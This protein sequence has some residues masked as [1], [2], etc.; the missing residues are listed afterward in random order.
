M[1]FLLKFLLV[2]LLVLLNGY[3]VASEFALVAVRKTRINELVK[4]G[5]KAAKLV[6]SAL[7][8]LDSFISSTQLGI[9]IA[10]LALGWI[11]EPA[12]ARFITPVFNFLPQTAATISAHTV[13]VAVAFLIITILHIVFGEL[14]PKTMALQ[15][16]EGIVLFIIRPLTIFTQVF[17]PFIF[18]LNGAGIWVLRIFGFKPPPGHQLVHSE[19][20]I[21]MILRQSVK[22]GVIEKEEAAMVTSVFKLGDITVKEIMVPRSQI[23]AFKIGITLMEMIDQI[24]KYPHSRFPIYKET[25]DHIVGFIHIKDV[26]ALLLRGGLDKKIAESDI[27][28]IF[29]VLETKKINEVLE[30]IQDKKVHIV[31]VKNILR[32][33]VGLITL[34]DILERLVGEIPDEFEQLRNTIRQNKKTF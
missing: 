6:K 14:A 29:S 11:G 26:Y 24:E 12:I 3:F 9:T 15:K 10:S 19:E 22:E 28:K 32:K 34:E 20:E 23:V 31:I 4:K 25:L 33:T 13:S 30:A 27:R 16:S 5:N 7:D 2:I 18:L 21:K 8:D 17:R 1:E